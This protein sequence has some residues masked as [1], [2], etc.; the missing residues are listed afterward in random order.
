MALCVT[1]RL[2]SMMPCFAHFML[3]TFFCS[4]LLTFCCSLSCMFSEPCLHVV[5]LGSGSIIYCWVDCFQITELLLYKTSQPCSLFLRVLM[6]QIQRFSEGARSEC[7]AQISNLKRPI[8]SYLPWTNDFNTSSERPLSAFKRSL[9]KHYWTN[10]TKVMAV[11]KMLYL[12]LGPQ[13]Y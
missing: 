2:I 10:R 6:V 1:N 4:M 8:V 9:K 3:L 13:K 11:Q 7:H 12:T 5:L